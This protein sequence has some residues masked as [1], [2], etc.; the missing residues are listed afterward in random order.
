MRVAGSRGRECWGRSSGNGVPGEVLE[1]F[2]TGRGVPGLFVVDP[3]PGRTE[4][5]DL[6][7]VVL[8]YLAGGFSYGVLL[9]P[10]GEV[11]KDKGDAV[12]DAVD[13]SVVL[14]ASEANGRDVDGDDVGR[15]WL[16][17][18]RRDGAELLTFF[19]GEGKLNRVPPYAAERVDDDA[20]ST[21]AREPPSAARS[22]QLRSRAPTALT[23]LGNL[24]CH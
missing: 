11:G 4:E 3:P 18:Q 15:N 10:G 21:C 7:F 17:I 13:A 1:L 6:D 12:F 22:T 5:D 23:P 16:R 2:G 20:T 19:A 9:R 8:C 14:C 24:E